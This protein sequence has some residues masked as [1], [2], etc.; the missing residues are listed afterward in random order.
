MK[1]IEKEAIKSAVSRVISEYAVK[2]K[3]ESVSL[4]AI[5]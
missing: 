3:E 5:P 4:Y 1:M 2:N